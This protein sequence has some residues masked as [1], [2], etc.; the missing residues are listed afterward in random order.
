MPNRN[1]Y[2]FSILSFLSTLSLSLS[3]LTRNGEMSPELDSLPKK[4][5]KPI[6]QTTTSQTKSVK[7]IQKPKATRNSQIGSYIVLTPGGSGSARSFI[8]VVFNFDE[9]AGNSDMYILL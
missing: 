1:N 4:S 7:L 9:T 8:Q 3:Y 2:S 6:L 5:L